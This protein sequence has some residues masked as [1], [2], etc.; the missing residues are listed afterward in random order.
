MGKDFN[1]SASFNN[2]CQF[3][4]SFKRECLCSGLRLDSDDFP[5]F[6]GDS[7]ELKKKFSSIFASKSQAE[8]CE[9]FDEVDA[10][11]APVVDLQEAHLHRHNHER[12]SFAKVN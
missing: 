11:V 5:Q 6:G 2:V 1:T 8:W 7:V 9:I 3:G 4:A 12:Q 10:C